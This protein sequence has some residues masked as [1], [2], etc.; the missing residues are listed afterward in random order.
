MTGG[1]FHLFL[2]EKRWP[3]T[4]FQVTFIRNDRVSDGEKGDL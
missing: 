2:L 4:E 3:N 1:V